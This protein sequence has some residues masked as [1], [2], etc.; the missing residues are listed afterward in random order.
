MTSLEVEHLCVYY[1]TT[2]ALWDISFSV[3]KGKIVG[4]IGPNGAG[5]STLLKALMGMQSPSSGSI[6]YQ[7]LS[8]SAA[9]G[10][11]AY[12][13]QRSSIDWD[14]PISVLD[15]VLMGRYRKFGLFK[16][17]KGA[18]KEAALRALEA[19]DMLPYATRQINR[20]S[21]GQQQRIFI[22]RALIQDASL[23]L[24]DEPFAGVDMATEQALFQI[25]RQLQIKG[26]TLFIIHHDLNTTQEY[27][28]WVLMLNTCLIAAGPV[29]EVF[30]VD[31]VMRTY[32]KNPVLLEEASK[33][34]SFQG[35]GRV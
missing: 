3:P 4:I 15:V 25:F 18:D 30:T 35:S 11:I 8:I 24:M 28:D 16:R 6:E 22:A 17:P 9:L 26:K 27:F 2:P 32:G 13:P 12:V 1:E 21:G 14:F 20:L 7:G 23:Y 34:S 33:L 19:V 10:N 29:N 5:K 31:N